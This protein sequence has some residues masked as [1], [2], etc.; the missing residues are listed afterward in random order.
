MIILSTDFSAPAYRG[1]VLY[2]ENRFYILN[3]DYNIFVME[4]SA[5]M[6]SV[7]FGP[8]VALFISILFMKPLSEI[9][10]CLSDV[11]SSVIGITSI[12]D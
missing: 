11:E 2:F 12:I 1:F 5:C 4:S 10:G 9:T 6:L 8:L 3:S 7:L